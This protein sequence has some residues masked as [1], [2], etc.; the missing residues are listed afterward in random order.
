[1]LLYNITILLAYISIVN[2]G[3]ASSPSGYFVE[4]IQNI[5]D[6]LRLN[7]QK[8]YQGAEAEAKA[9]TA[10]SSQ[11]PTQQSLS[12]TNNAPTALLNSPNT[13]DSPTMTTLHPKSLK[14]GSEISSKN[15]SQ[16][17]PSTGVSSADPAQIQP[18]TKSQDEIV[19]EV[20]PIQASSNFDSLA[21]RTGSLQSEKTRLPGSGGVFRQAS[22]FY[23]KVGNSLKTI[24][25]AAENV[26]QNTLQNSKSSINR[27]SKY[28]IGGLNKVQDDLGIRQNTLIK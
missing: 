24:N 14:E 20:I 15:I 22:K 4:A 8:I 12:N 26:G 11:P 7:L 10:R 21:H 6:A 13:N 3:C 17:T 1:M 9:K 23:G 28:L 19:K 27:G 5:S 18:L 25:S 2:A 16:D